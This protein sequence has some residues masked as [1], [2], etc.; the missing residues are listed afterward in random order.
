M[1]SLSLSSTSLSKDRDVTRPTQNERKGSSG[2]RRIKYQREW[3]GD[4]EEMTT[5]SA[6][7]RWTSTIYKSKALEAIT[8]RMNKPNPGCS[9]HR[10]CGSRASRSDLKITHRMT[11]P[12]LSQHCRRVQ[13][14]PH[15][16]NSPGPTNMQYIPRQISY[17]DGHAAPR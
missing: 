12:A 13:T 8:T 2:E 10:A 5:T 15:F 6:C 7:K 4:G 9:E 16:K 3:R 14:G 17:K 11:T 1:S